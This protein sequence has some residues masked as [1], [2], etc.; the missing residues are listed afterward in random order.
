MEDFL[1]LRAGEGGWK[2]VLVREAERLGEAAQNA[3]LKTLEEP[4]PRVL[5]A[6][7][8]SRPERLLPT[9]R[10]RLV[11]VRL[12]PL[13]AADAEAVLG[14]SGH[15]WE[16]AGFRD[17]GPGG[18]MGLLSELLRTRVV[19]EPSTHSSLAS[20]A[21]DAAG[22]QTL[23]EDAV[24]QGNLLIDEVTLHTPSVA[25]RS[26]RELVEVLANAVFVQAGLLPGAEVTVLQHRDQ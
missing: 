25:A 18:F 23:L 3:F 10:S 16:N 20:L 11:R 8:S 22:W 7:E 4:R 13:S 19:A 2:V 1:D 21:E 17:L 9:V 6:L 26:S 5:L 15:P 24:A 14:L 12:E